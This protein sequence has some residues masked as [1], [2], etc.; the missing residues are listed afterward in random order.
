MLDRCFLVSRFPLNNSKELLVVNTHNSAYDDGS[1]RKQQMTYLK[2]FLLSEYA[3]GNY[4]IVGGDW[5]QSPYGLPPEL[6][7]HPFDTLNLTYVDE[8]YPAPD[9]TW[10][11]DPGIP[12]NRRVTTPYDRTTS[13]TTIIDYYLISPNIKVLGVSTL[14]LD[15]KYSD[16]QPVTLDVK[17]IA[18]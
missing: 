4:I 5:N 11:Y 3:Q 12:T 6:P 9:W 10:A 1:L 2:D 15:F 14:D 7:S 17:L 18:G 13:L 16:H 8:G